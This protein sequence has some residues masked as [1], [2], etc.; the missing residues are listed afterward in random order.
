MPSID[1]EYF[2]IELCEITGQYFANCT[3]IRS[4]A[5]TFCWAVWL[6]EVSVKSRLGEDLDFFAK[7][8]QA[9]TTLQILSPR[10]K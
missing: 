2:T 8:Y 1:M 9:S 4:N 10:L 3:S 6:P 5:T 7:L